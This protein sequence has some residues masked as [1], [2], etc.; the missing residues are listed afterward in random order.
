MSIDGPRVWFEFIAQE[1][2]ANRDKLADYGG[3][4]TN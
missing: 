3:E 4:F 2:V 1:D